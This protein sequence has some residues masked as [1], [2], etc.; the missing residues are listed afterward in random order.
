VNL[1]VRAKAVDSACVVRLAERIEQRLSSLPEYMHPRITG[2][3]VL[4]SRAV[5]DVARGQIK[6][7]SLAFVFI[8]AILAGLF[9]SVRVGFLALLP[10]AL[11]VVAYFGLLGLTGVALDTTTGLVACIVLGIAVD[12][13]IHLLARFNFEA[14]E[15]VNENVA[16]V[17]AL[18][19]VASPVTI[20]T[21]G[22]CLGFL[23]LTASEF[24]NQVHFGI[25]GAL[26]LAFA[27]LVDV[28]FTPALCAGMHVV[29][30]WDILTLDLGE[31]P[32][33]SISL[34]RGL[35]KTQAR[36]AAL[37]TDMVN[38]PAS[39]SVFRAGDPGDECYVVLD[40]E[41]RVSIDTGDRRVELNRA[42]YGDVVGEVALYRGKRTAD[43]E[44]VTEVRALRFTREN[45]ERLRRRH[46]RIGARV[47]WNL[48]EILADHV[49]NATRR[50]R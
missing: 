15:R 26:T 23:A 49:D 44:T 35:S 6:S 42:R 16:A 17:C 30:L 8:F 18:K 31:E 48:S 22:V 29:T 9:T 28:T 24:Q 43:V 11:P 38:F 40:G 32:Q 1:H 13:T 19:S 3:T 25:L 14:R 5:N 50:V 33:H 12:D 4:L 47:F 34:L 27:W 46:P 20:T 41:L 37:T 21:V 45:L 39:T 7:L 2:S 36:I 10:N